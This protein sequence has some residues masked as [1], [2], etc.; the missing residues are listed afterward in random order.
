[1]LFTAQHPFD[2]K[3]RV[4]VANLNLPGNIVLIRPFEK[5]INHD[6]RQEQPVC[7]KIECH[8]FN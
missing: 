1:V 3:I 2:I 8:K 4:Q 6:L 7:S 5:F